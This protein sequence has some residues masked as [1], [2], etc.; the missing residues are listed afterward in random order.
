MGSK[1]TNKSALEIMERHNVGLAGVMDAHGQFIGVVTQ[2][3][4]VRKPLTW[5]M[6]EA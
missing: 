2:E 4:I 3:E 6:R 5:L 1:E